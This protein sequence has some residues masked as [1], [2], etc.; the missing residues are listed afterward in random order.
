MLPVEVDKERINSEKTQSKTVIQ[1]QNNKPK[2]QKHAA[3]T[4][5]V[6][7]HV[8]QQNLL[9]DHIKMPWYLYKRE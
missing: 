9:F 7:L 5:F 4:V 8:F 3:D 6:V 2:Y 1:E